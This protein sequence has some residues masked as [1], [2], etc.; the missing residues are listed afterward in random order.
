MNI[1]EIYNTDC[2]E[3]MKAMPDASVD[4]VITS[5]PYNFCLRVRGGGNNGGGGNNNPPGELEE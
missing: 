5:P 4:A 1:D 2:L 3:G